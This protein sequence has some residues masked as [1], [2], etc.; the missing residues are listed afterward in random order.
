VLVTLD[1]KKSS[2]QSALPCST[3]LNKI[4]DLGFTAHRQHMFQL[5]IFHTSLRKRKNISREKLFIPCYNSFCILFLENT[6]GE[7][8]GIKV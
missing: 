8:C 4:S 3:Q 6:D 2:N 5:Y 1:E 7:K